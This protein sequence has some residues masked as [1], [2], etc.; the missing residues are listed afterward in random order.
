VERISSGWLGP[1]TIAIWAALLVAVLGLLISAQVFCRRRFRRRYNPWL[2]GSTTLTLALVGIMAFTAVSA[3]RLRTAQTSL[4]QVISSR[5]EQMSQT[6]SSGQLALAA[7]LKKNCP[8]GCGYTVGHFT[9]RL[10]P[11]PN[12][13]T[14]A[15]A[16]NRQTQAVNERM[17]AAAETYGLG[18]AIPALAILILGGIGAG[19]YPRISEYRFDR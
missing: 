8:A 5:N 16:I 1:W 9:E 3:H 13:P 4:D 12:V 2:L 15:G 7:M 19:L 11:A 14:G 6:D 18:I 10:H 17:D